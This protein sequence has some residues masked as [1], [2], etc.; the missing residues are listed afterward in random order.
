MAQQPINIVRLDSWVSPPPFFSQDF[1]RNLISHHN[2]VHEDESIIERLLD[3]DIVV[4]TRVPI[5]AKTVEV[6]AKRRLRLV[7]VFAIGVDMVDLEACRKHGVEVRNVKGASVESV[8]E[9]AL[10]FYFALRRNVVGMHNILTTTNTWLEK[11]NCTSHFFDL[12]RTLKDET[13]G[14]VGV[15]EL[16]TRVASHFASLGSKV[17]FS[18]RPSSASIREG[19]TAFTEVLKSSTVLI[20]CTALNQSTLNLISS[21]ELALLP[22]D[23]L[24]I[25]IARG[26][27]V[28]ESALVDALKEM[29]IAGAASDVFLKEPTG[30]EENILVRE[31]ENLGGRL[32][33]S[34]HVAW[35]ARAST[36]K[37]RRVTGENIETWAKGEGKGG[38]NWVC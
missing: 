12:S 28:D 6:C 37:L 1:N 9:H 36:D 32:V 27:I 15:G 5:S 19:R 17:L 25:N 18:E 23:A 21:A 35:W 3:A 34:P 20:V 4:T 13:I 7:V 10:G 22:S 31:A 26:G 8:A 2:T 29:K 38:E 16:G 11:G 30:T 14:I 24:L 33:L